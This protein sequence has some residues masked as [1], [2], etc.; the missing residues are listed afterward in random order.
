V[1][2]PQYNKTCKWVKP[3]LGSVF[4]ESYAKYVPAFRAQC[5]EVG[6]YACIREITGY[7]V[8]LERHAAGRSLPG[9][10]RHVLKTTNQPAL[11]W[12]IDDKIVKAPKVPDNQDWDVGIMRNRELEQMETHLEYGPFIFVNTTTSGR[13]FLDIWCEMTKWGNDHRAQ[14]AAIMMTFGFMR[15]FDCEPWLKGC[16]EMRGNDYRKDLTI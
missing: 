6:V 5:D 1:K 15:Y 3:V 16:V 9:A 10:V 12:G 11:F 14:C 2:I 13:E 4:T 8:G 7:A